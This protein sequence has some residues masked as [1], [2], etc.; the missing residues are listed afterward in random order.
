MPLDAAATQ[1][2]ASKLVAVDVSS[3]DHNVAADFSAGYARS[4]LVGGPTA[5]TLTTV[6]VDTVNSTG[7]T[8]SVLPGT[9]VKALI[10]KVYHT[11][12][13]ATLLVAFE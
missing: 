2:S 3:T 9:V 10:T 6:K 11:G 1:F 7:V 8:L 4:L 13:S 5:G 12:T